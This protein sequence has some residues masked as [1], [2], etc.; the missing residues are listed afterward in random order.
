MR[1][2]GPSL[3]RTNSA[4]SGL[5]AFR[6]YESPASLASANEQQETRSTAQEEVANDPSSSLS[7]SPE[8][9]SPLSSVCDGMFAGSACLL[10]M[11]R[12]VQPQPTAAR[13]SPRS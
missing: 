1:R 13:E 6:Q 11:S 9:P 3:T 12:E 2:A 10:E 8:S 4:C 7:N 5:Q